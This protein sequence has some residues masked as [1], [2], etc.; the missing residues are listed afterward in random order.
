MLYKKYFQGHICVICFLFALMQI[1][2]MKD[3]I[4]KPQTQPTSPFLNKVEPI[5][6]GNVEISGVM[7]NGFI[8]VPPVLA[9]LVLTVFV[10]P[11]FQ[12]L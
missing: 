7:N 12:Y 10:V 1:S 8:K 6:I 4:L 11:L 2:C 3:D 9:Q 5:V